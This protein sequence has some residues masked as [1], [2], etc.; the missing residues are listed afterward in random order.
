MLNLKPN[1]RLAICNPNLINVWDDPWILDLPLSRKPTYFNMHLID[2]FSVNFLIS[3]GA[4]NLHACF[5]FFGDDLNRVVF[6]YIVFYTN[7]KND[8]VW[9]PCSN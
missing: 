2:N 1:L 3:D 8:W 7:V 6:N 9:R 4:F 5:V